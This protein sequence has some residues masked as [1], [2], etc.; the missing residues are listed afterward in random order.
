MRVFTVLVFLSISI[1]ISA[2]A[3]D[4]F[5]NNPE[6]RQ[7]SGQDNG[8]KCV[9]HEEYVYYLNGDS[10]IGNITY[11]KLF[12]HGTAEYQ[13]WDMPPTPE[14]CQG[15]WT[16]DQFH[17]LLRQEE[18]K[19]YIHPS[20]E[21]EELLYNFELEIGDTLPVTWNQWDNNI[22]V[23]SIDSLL[24]GTNYRKVFNLTNQG[25][26]Q[27]I[28]G[29]GHERGFLEPFSEML[30][31]ASSLNCFALNDT[32]YY[33]EIGAPC[34]LTVELPENMIS[35]DVI[36]YPN[37]VSDLLN[38]ELIKSCDIKQITAIDINGKTTILGFVKT[39]QNKLMV[40]MS[41]L[42]KGLYVIQIDT[43]DL[44]THRLKVIKE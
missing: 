44:I 28:E 37:P 2:Q 34:D 1:S 40:D 14:Y 5:S 41:N 36:F 23:T 17:T 18:L 21:P 6:W 33:P 35:E 30:D 19:I 29:I 4:Y 38:I 9:K 27:L 25:S 43:K 11:R 42:T 31:F 15:S 13:W 8:E 24:F 26:Q 22:V 39:K 3:V 12:K 16:F 7:S 20:G 32:V 10:I